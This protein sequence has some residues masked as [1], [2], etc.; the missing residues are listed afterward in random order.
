MFLRSW[1]FLWGGE[2]NK[3]S[4]E[5][6]SREIT[7]ERI[8]TPNSLFAKMREDLLSE[9]LVDHN[10]T[11]S[12]PGR[13]VELRLRLEKSPL[14][15]ALE[16]FKSL[17]VMASIFSDTPQQNKTSS[18]TRHNV[19]LSPM[20]QQIDLLLSELNGSGTFDLLG[21]G[22]LREDYSVVLTLDRAF[23]SD[24]SLSDIVDGE[25]TV[26]GKI[27]KKIDVYSD[28]TI[29]LFRKSG[30]GKVRGQLL[31]QMTSS[32]NEVREQGLDVPPIIVEIEAPVV[33]I[34]PIA[35]FV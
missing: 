18:K 9:G 1:V 12:E 4:T 20:L 31:Q 22:V 32:F 24:P 30:L 8:N 13:F 27:T 11:G 19:S 34:I 10:V 25:Y 28:E 33:Q 16:S 14:V 15:I 17:G 2:R 3:K 23:L 29:N 21:H 5:S 26:I 35:I 7:A 6:D